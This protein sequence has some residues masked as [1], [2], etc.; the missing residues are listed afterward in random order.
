M[1]HGEDW[2]KNYGAHCN[3]CGQSCSC[4]RAHTVEDVYTGCEECQQGWLLT[5]VSVGL[6]KMRQ[7]V[8]KA[9]APQQ[10]PNSNLRLDH[11]PRVQKLYQRSTR[12]RASHPSHKLSVSSSHGARTTTVA[13][14]YRQSAH[15][16]G[17]A[18]INAITRRRV[19]ARK[20]STSARH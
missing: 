17:K 11:C 13:Q 12:R 16:I 19:P 7:I 5:T 20:Q 4:C 2:V 10:P 14:Q 18:S 6:K 3:G 8:P 15:K 9:A 1:T